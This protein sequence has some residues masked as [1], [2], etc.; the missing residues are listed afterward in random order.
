MILPGMLAILCDLGM[1][2]E[3]KQR[4]AN[5]LTTQ[6][7]PAR[8]WVGKIIYYAVNLLYA[9]LLIFSGIFVGGI[10]M[11][12]TIPL[13]NGL[14][15]ALLL[16]VCYLWEIPFYMMLSTCFGMFA[17]I[18][19]CMAVTVGSLVTLGASK[20]WWICPASVP[21]RLMCPVL[22]IMPNGL[23]VEEGSRYVDAAVILPGVVISV[24]WFLAF[25][26]L[27]ARWFQNTEME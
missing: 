11:G 10:F 5:L 8:C 20:L 27:T 22:G 13:R 23:L 3:K 14:I 2:K 17:D 26:F 16:S 15:A 1:K 7:S 19:V 12:T 21:F 9:N 6:I 4:Y 25:T 24:V 18:F